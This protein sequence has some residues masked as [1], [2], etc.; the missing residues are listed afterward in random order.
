MRFTYSANLI[1]LLKYLVKYTNYEAFYAIFSILVLPPHS[2]TKLHLL[3]DQ[4]SA[5]TELNPL[6]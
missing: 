4:S 2:K 5:G 6:T 1:L 3:R